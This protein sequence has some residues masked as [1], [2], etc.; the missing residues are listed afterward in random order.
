[1]HYILYSY[2]KVSLKNIKIIKYIYNTE[3]YL[4]KKNLRIKWAMQ[5]KPMLFKG[6]WYFLFSLSHECTV[7]FFPKIS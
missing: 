2:N 4:L 5:F 7:G 1:M 6:Q 3:L